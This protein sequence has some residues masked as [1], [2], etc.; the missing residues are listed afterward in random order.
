MLTCCY[1]FIFEPLDT[2]KPM[3]VERHCMS[4]V[5]FNYLTSFQ[6]IFKTPGKSISRTDV[7]PSWLVKISFSLKCFQRH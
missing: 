4:V 2:P 5:F 7:L 3:S 1:Q 6:R